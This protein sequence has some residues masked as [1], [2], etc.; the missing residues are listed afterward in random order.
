MLLAGAPGEDGT[1]AAEGEDVVGSCCYLCDFLQVRE[2][3]RPS[4]DL[5]CCRETENPVIA[6][7]QSFVSICR[8]GR[9]K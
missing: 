7:V 6:L 5:R 8:I 3:N 9:E 4:L 2:E 1:A